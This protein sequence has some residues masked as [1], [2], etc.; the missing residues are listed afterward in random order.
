MNRQA[1][2]T[3]GSH[4]PWA[5]DHQAHLTAGS[6]HPWPPGPPRRRIARAHRPARQA[7]LE[8]GAHA[9]RGRR[10]RLAFSAVTHT[11]GTAKTL[12]RL[13][14]NR[15]DTTDLDATPPR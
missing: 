2:L 7:A 11:C 4:H 8:R 14:C 3:A 5:M 9:V 6:H 15:P 12:A 10:R 1:H 13:P